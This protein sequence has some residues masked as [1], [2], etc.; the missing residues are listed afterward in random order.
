MSICN[1]CGAEIEYEERD[2]DLYCPECGWSKI[3]ADN[4][5]PIVL[6]NKKAKAL[7]SVRIQ[8][9]L[10]TIL[11]WGIFGILSVTVDVQSIIADTIARGLGLGVIIWIIF[12]I[13]CIIRGIK[14]KTSKN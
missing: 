12:T 14:R 6:K 11:F 4:S 7:D 2:D 1:K 9:L 3:A 13:S 5:T 8:W 10:V